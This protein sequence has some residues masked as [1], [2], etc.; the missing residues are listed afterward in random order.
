MGWWRISGP[1][2]HVKWSAVTGQSAAVLFN[3]IPG[4]HDPSQLYNGDEPADVLDAVI[5]NLADKLREPGYL[6]AVKNVF[7]QFA[8]ED[9]I[10]PKTRDMLQ[11]ARQRIGDVYFREWQRPPTLDEVSAVFEFCT[12][13]FKVS[14]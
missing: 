3:Y 2:G 11:N 4:R 8:E 12:Q 1:T 6:E 9:G 7:L 5:S 10:D 13:Q 14:T